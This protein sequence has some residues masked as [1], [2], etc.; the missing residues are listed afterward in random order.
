MRRRELLAGAIGTGIVASGA[1]IAIRGVPGTGADPMADEDELA[2]GGD[3]SGAR[4]PIEVETIEATG[5]E[6]GAVVVPDAERVTFIE[7]FATWCTSCQSMM[8]DLNEAASRVPET[9]RFMSVTSEPVGDRLPEEELRAWWDEHDGNWT[10]GI[11]PVS[12]LSVRYDGVPFPRSVAIDSTGVIQWDHTGI[13]DAEAILAGIET[14]LEADAE[15]EGEI[16][17]LE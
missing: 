17:P 16:E 4:E 9:V 12:E 8:P 13:T 1:A 15:I 11:D 5:S 10:L 6:A 7:F 2:S 3:E 14:T